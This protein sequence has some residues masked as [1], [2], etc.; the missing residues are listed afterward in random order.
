MIQV[1]R[2][3]TLRRRIRRRNDPEALPF[4]RDS[5]A[6]ILFVMSRVRVSSST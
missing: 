2:N 5:T 3:R 1:I 6:L 4:Q